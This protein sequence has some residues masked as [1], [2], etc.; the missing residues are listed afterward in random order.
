LG[1][2]FSESVIQ[3]LQ[4]FFPDWIEIIF[5]VLTYFGDKIIYIIILAIAFWVFKKRDAIVTIYIL[6]TSSFLYFFLKAI[7]QKPRPS[8][9]LRVVEVEGFSTPSGHATTS[10]TVYGWIMFYFKKIW[11]YIVV[12]ILVLLICFSR[13]VLGVHFLGDVILGF[14]IGCVLLAASYFGIPYLLKWMDTWPDWVK[15]LVGEVYG[16]IIFFATFLTAIYANWP[17]EKDV[18]NSADFVPALILFPIYI[19]I[20]HKWIKMDNEKL[21]ISSIILRIVIGLAL[22]VGTYFGLSFLFDLIVLPA[23]PFMKEYTIEYFLRFARYA[24]IY[25]IVALGV[26]LLFSKVKIF[27]Q[28]R[29][30]KSDTESVD[31]Q[32]EI[33]TN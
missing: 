8:E 30:A 23:L 32:N 26:P 24:I 17:S 3:A 22:V 2:F 19:W 18:A 29:P 31:Y 7:I 6:L 1:W 13:V 20:E 27:K 5:K 25:T 11:L 28:K 9:S 14:L 21:A 4:D 33:S 10:A 16:V 12:P 15:I